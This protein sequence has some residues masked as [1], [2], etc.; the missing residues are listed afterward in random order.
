MS[1]VRAIVRELFSLW[2][3]TYLIGQSLVRLPVGMTVALWREPRSVYQEG[4][5][6]WARSNMRAGLMRC[7]VESR[8]ELPPSAILV[9]NH[10]H[11]FD[12]HLLF[13]LV[14]VPVYFIARAEV[15]RIPL[16]GFILK[17][18][19]HLTVE[20]GGGHRNDTAFEEA[21][22]RLREGGRI[23]FF[24]EGTR[25]KDGTIQPLRS[26]AFRLAAETGVPLVPVVLA[27]TDYV[28]RRRY[29]QI[30]P[31]RMAARFLEPRRV[32]EKQSRSATYREA[33]RAEMA[34]ALAEL[35]P[36]TGA[37]I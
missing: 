2:V 30:V 20:R 32:S 3:W 22:A 4:M 9:A 18:G 8:G 29:T 1:I 16:V 14:D 36:T 12:I 28:F 24:G 19:G 7:R 34:A 33:V 11:F 27:G 35:A 10:R 21:A 26:G 13:A 31:V 37:R 25:S 6:A 23:V 17:R 15:T 5:C